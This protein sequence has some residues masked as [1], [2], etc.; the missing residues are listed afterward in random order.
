MSEMLNLLGM[1]LVNA[2]TL[3]NML[4][5]AA[6]VI[7]GN[8]I[9]ALPGLTPTMAV[10]VA[11]PI[12]FVLSPVASIAFLMG[13][14]KGG[15]SGC[16]LTAV[17]IGVPGIPAATCTVLDGFQLMK[18]G[19][20]HK[21]MQMVIYSSIIADVFG[22]L[23][24][25]AS[26]TPLAYIAVK[27]GPPEL[28]ALLIFSLATV[29]SVTGDQP[30]KGLISAAAGL[31]IGTVGLDPVA[32][33]PRLTFHFI[34]FM[35][36]FSVIPVLIGMFAIPEILDQ[37]ERMAKGIKES[38]LAVKSKNPEDN[39]VTL[40]DMRMCAGTILRGSIIGSIVGAIPGI[41]SS[42]AAFITYSETVRAS[43]HPE[44]FGKGALEGV[45]ASESGNSGVNGP[46]LIPLLTLGIPGETVSAVLLGAF[47]IHGLHPGPLLM[48]QHAVTIYTM[49][50]AL[51]IANVIN[52]GVGLLMIKGIQYIL[53]LS[54]AIMFPVIA[55]L[56]VIG[57]YACD[58]SAFDIK[59][60]AIFGVLGYIMKEYN[61]P[62]APMIIALL[63][64]PMFETTLRQSLLME[65]GSLL[66]FLHSP[67]AIG[68]LALTVLLVILNVKRLSKRIGIGEV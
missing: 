13:I 30:L 17:A 18:Q 38:F 21:A 50:G 37:V 31:L 55:V 62:R 57:A 60:M 26:C 40:K 67:I 35:S 3:T 52:L 16:G 8:I 36:G 28:T 53:K 66:V 68:F 44:R 10:A 47:T 9:G 59:L 43:K 54:M 34:S 61:F 25:V 5:I 63:L 56:C 6:G 23:V 12:T 64:G 15:T 48:K 4:L 7:I 32:G 39:R 22:D 33:S 1:G 41:G 42:V 51:L 29:G 19:K 20:G 46:A 24:M 11:L 2:F 58:N 45:A 14:A 27:F 65:R 49:F